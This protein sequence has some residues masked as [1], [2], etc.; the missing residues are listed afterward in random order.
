MTPLGGLLRAF[1][2]CIELDREEPVVS[3][4]AQ[5][6]A[7]GGP[8]YTGAFAGDHV[9]MLAAGQVLDVQVPDPTAEQLDDDRDRLADHHA[10]PE[11]LGHRPDEISAVP[12]M[13]SLAP[14]ERERLDALRAAIGRGEQEMPAT[15]DTVALLPDGTRVPLAVALGHAESDGSRW[16]DPLA[17]STSRMPIRDPRLD[18][19]CL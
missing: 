3:R 8:V 19:I 10:V 5:R 4:A 13:M 6:I 1:R 15:V 9:V 2:V 12:V 16:R 11:L 18:R 7:Q 14:E 17:L